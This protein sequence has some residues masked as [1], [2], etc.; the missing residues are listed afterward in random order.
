VAVMGIQSVQDV[1]LIRHAY[2]LPAHQGHG[3]GGALLRRLRSL[4]SIP[5]LAAALF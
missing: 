2:V 4:S 3:I 1:D 5:P